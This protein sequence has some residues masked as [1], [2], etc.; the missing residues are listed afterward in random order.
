MQLDDTVEP[1]VRHAHRSV[2]G[3]LWHPAPGAQPTTRHSLV[4]GLQLQPL[5]HQANITQMG[6]RVRSAWMAPTLATITVGP[7]VSAPCTLRPAPRAPLPAQSRC[8]SAG[9][10]K[11][12]TF[13]DGVCI[14]STHSGD[15]R[16]IIGSRRARKT[17]SVAIANGSQSHANYRTLDWSS[18]PLNI[19]ISAKGVAKQRVAY[20]AW[21]NTS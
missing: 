18:T 10:N 1:E 11:S 7:I 16:S 13:I 2:S 15:R 6:V 12:S 5:I 3:T 14:P 19:Q 8:A 4:C 21:P 17:S 20:P 9:A